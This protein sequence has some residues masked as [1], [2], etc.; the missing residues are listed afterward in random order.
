MLLCWKYFI[1]NGGGIQYFTV[2]ENTGCDYV[3]IQFRNFSNILKILYKSLTVLLLMTTTAR[4]MDFDQGNWT[5]FEEQAKQNFMSSFH[6]TDFFL[7]STALNIA[8]ILSKSSFKA[9]YRTIPWVLFGLSRD[10]CWFSK[11]SENVYFFIGILYVWARNMYHQ[12]ST[13][14]NLRSEAQVV[15]ISQRNL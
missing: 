6:E 4:K 3:I 1:Q 14:S 12:Y 15:L 7:A 10:S 11:L 13:F 9:T 5:N 2:F 8:I